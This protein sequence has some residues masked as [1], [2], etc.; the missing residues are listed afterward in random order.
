MKRKGKEIE[1]NENIIKRLC[2]YDG[3]ETDWYIV[4]MQDCRVDA[5]FEFN[6]Y[7][8]HNERVGFN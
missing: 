7:Q 4:D 2:E 5:Q 6:H 3:H 8:P 1:T